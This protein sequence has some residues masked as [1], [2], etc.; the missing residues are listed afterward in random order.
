MYTFAMDKQNVIDTA[1]DA[2]IEAALQATEEII[3]F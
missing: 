3:P 1:Y 2:V